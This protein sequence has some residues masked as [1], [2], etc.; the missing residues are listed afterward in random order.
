MKSTT[1][2]GVAAAALAAVAVPVALAPSAAAN[3]EQ[4]R[5]DN[6]SASE[7]CAV[8]KACYVRVR[9]TGDNR[10]DDVTITVNGNVIGYAVPQQETWDTAAATA[11]VTWVPSDYGNFTII[12]KQGSSSA[13]VNFELKRPQSN[14]P[15]T[16]SFGL[17]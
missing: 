2:T 9:L 3:T 17:G 7:T 8:G 13:S 5:V 4:V 6:V 15:S 11:E 1:F 14:A 16:G 12:A 10:L